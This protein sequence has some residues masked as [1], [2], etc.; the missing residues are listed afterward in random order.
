LLSIP[1]TASS[2]FSTPELP[3]DVLG[4]SFEGIEDGFII[5]FLTSTVFEGFSCF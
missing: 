4:I 2:F 3:V 5:S 1:F